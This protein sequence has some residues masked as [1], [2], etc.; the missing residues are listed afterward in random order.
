MPDNNGELDDSEIRVGDVS[1]TM[2]VGS[3][4][5][6]NNLR[7]TAGY[8]STVTV[9]GGPL[10]DPVKRRPISH[11]PRSTAEPLIGR[12]RDL[13]ILHEAVDAHQLVQVWGASGVGKSALLRHLARTL[14]PGPEGAAYI[15][16]GGRTADDIAQAIFDISFDAPNYKPSLEVLKEHL[17]TLRLRIYLDD[18]GLDEKDLRRLFDLA[19]LSTFVLTAEQRSTVGA[20]HAIRL[21]GLTPPAT[22]QLVE[23]LLGRALR[24]DEAATVAALRDVVDGSPLQ[25]RRIASAAATGAGLPGIADLPELLPALVRRLQPQEH[26]LLHLLGSVSGAELAARHL[27]DLLGRPDG[28]AVADGLVRRGLLLASET[29]YSCPPDVAA[30][31]LD[32][33]AT[34]FPADRLCRALTVWVRATDTAPDDVAAHFR[35]LDAAVVGAERSGHAALGAGLAR[36]ASPK[37]ALSRQFDAWGSLLG[38]GWSAAKSAGDKEGEEFFLREARTRRKAIGRAALTTALVLEADVLW[39]E[40]T[41]LRGHTAIQQVVNGASAVPPPAHPVTPPVTHPPAHPVTPAHTPI[42]TA[43]GAHTASHASTA[44]AHLHASAAR[45]V[46]N[47]SHAAQQPP[48]AAAHTAASA[49]HGAGANPAAQIP[50]RIDLSHAHTSATHTSA[51]QSPHAAS[52]GVSAGGSGHA[53]LAPVVAVGAKGGMSALAIACALGLVTVLGVGAAAYEHSRPDPSPA[54]ASGPVSTPPVDDISTTA[55]D[56][57]STPTVDPVCASLVSDL[58]PEIEQ[59]S[60]DASAATDEMDTYNS[61][62]GDWNSGEAAT[63]P[64]SGAVFSAVRTVISDLGSVES[65]LETAALQAQDDDVATDVNSMLDP[66]QQMESLYQSYENSAQGTDFDT[67]DQQSSI[68]SAADSLDTDCGE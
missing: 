1:G 68:L 52:T 8:G 26:D 16:A 30:Y 6:V 5:T 20:V 32:S 9:H 65:T 55:P 17:K 7:I 31:V 27:N 29:G 2:V 54:V 34:T 41:V 10:P 13:R 35:V 58:P 25:L 23:A 14:P 3:H 39:H 61:A 66:V 51:A 4:N 18:A 53:A 56:D 38:A 33:R 45:P 57:V 11:L 49:A 48:A 43:G 36:A 40:L 67:L 22:A 28:D 60:T 46:V 37:L 62:M 63:A 12:A 42:H 59:F 15:E 44:S 64:D 19:Q 21:E 47:L 50:Q 24:P